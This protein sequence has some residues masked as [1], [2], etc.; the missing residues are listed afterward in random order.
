MVLWG[1]IWEFCWASM[2]VGM[3]ADLASWWAHFWVLLAGA[4]CAARCAR[5]RGWKCSASLPRNVTPCR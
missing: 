3:T 5:K 1:A 2:P 4:C